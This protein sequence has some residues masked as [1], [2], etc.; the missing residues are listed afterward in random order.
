MKNNSKFSFAQA[1]RQLYLATGGRPSDIEVQAI[2]ACWGMVYA[3]SRNGEWEC[4]TFNFESPT[5]PDAFYSSEYEELVETECR[6]QL[7]ARH[8]LN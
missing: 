4:A 1:C 5:D 2:D 8:S 7:I 6:R 3:R